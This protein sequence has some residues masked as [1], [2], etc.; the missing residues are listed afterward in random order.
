M[1]L[2][3]EAAIAAPS[4]T[5]WSILADVERWPEWTAS[6]KSIRLLDGELRVGARVEV[7]QPKLPKAVWTVSRL[8]EGSRFDW[9]AHSTGLTTVGRHSVEPSATGSRA[10]LGFEQTGPLAGLFG[11]LLGKLARDYVAMEMAGL[12]ERSEATR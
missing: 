2:E 10:K 3:Q 1:N 9:T 7:V 6:M 8:D 4:S 11:L 12:K 5:V